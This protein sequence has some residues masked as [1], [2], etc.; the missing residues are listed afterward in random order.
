MPAEKFA[1]MFTRS[2]SVCTLKPLYEK[3]EQHLVVK[4]L[5]MKGLGARRIHIKL[6]WVVGDDCY[7][8]AATERWLARFR[9]GDLSCADHS[10]SSHP[11]IDISESLRAFI[12]KFPS[13][14]ANMMSRHFRIARGSIMEILQRDLGFQSSPIDECYISSAHHTKLIASIVLELYCTCCHSYSCSIL[15]E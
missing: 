2:F 13:A 15:S 9:E 7:G 6:S 8:P 14:S 3:S 11:V 1:L 5:W 4:F 10:R 12:N